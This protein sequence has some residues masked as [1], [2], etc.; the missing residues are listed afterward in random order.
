MFTPQR[1]EEHVFIS[2]WRLQKNSAGNGIQKVDYIY[3]SDGKRIIVERSWVADGIG[4]GTPKWMEQQGE[5][6]ERTG[7]G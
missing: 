7:D 2:I 3:T 6:K 4:T 1:T 5:R